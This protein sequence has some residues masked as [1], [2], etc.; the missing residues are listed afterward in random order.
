MNMYWLTLLR[1]ALRPRG[2]ASEWNFFNF[3]VI[4]VEMQFLLNTYKIHLYVFE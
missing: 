1:V 2:H 4:G 3:V